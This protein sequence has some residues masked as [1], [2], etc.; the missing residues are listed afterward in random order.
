[1]DQQKELYSKIATLET[2]VDMLETELNCLNDIL[3]RCGFPEGIKT[4]KSTALELLRQEGV[5][6]M[7]KGLA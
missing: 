1:M 5:Y 4:L 3:T 2:E 7:K 6:A